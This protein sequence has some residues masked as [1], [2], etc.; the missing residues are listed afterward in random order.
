M[1]RMVDTG[2]VDII[3]G[4]WLSEMN[5]AWNAITKAFNPSLGYEAGFLAQLSTCIES[6][7]EKKLKVVTNAGALNTA[8]LKD[9]VEALC[10]ERGLDL[11]VAGV[12]GDDISALLAKGGAATELSHL[13]HSEWN[14]KDWERAEEI[15]CG[16]AYIGAWG[17]T[18][19]LD[20]GADIV[21]CGRVTDAS[22]VIGAA[23]WWYGWKEED[24][25]KLAG[26]LVAGRTLSRSP[27]PRF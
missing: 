21:I 24:Y 22:P 6:I 4:D 25:D 20:A 11:K 19:A 7:A 2:S 10:A 9:E 17:I 27:D 3:T 5:I 18:A 1:R 23:A 15:T 14:L 16:V 13:D 8:A 26:A 12:Y